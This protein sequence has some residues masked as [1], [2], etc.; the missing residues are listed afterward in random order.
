ML[1]DMMRH[2]ETQVAKDCPADLR[3]AD[4]DLGFLVDQEGHD[5]GLL[6]LMYLIMGLHCIAWSWRSMHDFRYLIWNIL[7]QEG[8]VSAVAAKHRLGTFSLSFAAL[9]T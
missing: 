2:R 5:R 8:P 6:V 9:V 1:G 3:L 7:R 4:V